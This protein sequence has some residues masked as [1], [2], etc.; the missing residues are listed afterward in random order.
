MHDGRTRWRGSVLA[1]LFAGLFCTAVCAQQAHQPN[2]LLISLDT[3][4]ADHL[5]CYGYARDTSPNLDR[6]AKEGVLF[7]SMTAASSW[8]V[9]SHMS[10]FTSLYPSVHGV[11]DTKKQLGEAVPTMAEILAKHGYTTAGFVTGPSLNHSMGFHR[12]FGFYDDFTVTLMHD[13]NLF[14]DLDADKSGIN[15]VPTNHVI[16]NLATAWL[17]KNAGEKFFLFLHYWDCH[18]DYI[19]PEPYDR[20]FYLEYEGPENGRNVTNRQAEL[21]RSASPETKKRLI[22]LYDGEIAHTDAHVGKMLAALDELKLSERTLVI[23][24]SDHGEGFWEH[25]RLHHGNNLYEELIHVPLLMRLPGVL[26]AGLRV[27]GNASHVDVLPTL[28]GLLGLPQQN[29]IHGSD[30]SQACRGK[31]DAPD[32][33]IYSEL[34]YGEYRMR[35]VR[36]G[37]YKVVQDGG[38]PGPAA[39]R[40]Q[41]GRKR[42]GEGRDGRE[43]RARRSASVDRCAQRRAGERDNPRTARQAGQTGREDAALAAQPGISG[44]ESE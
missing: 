11:E 33:P 5:G 1:I 23:I 25:G 3:L 10:M 6:F 8:T 16:T 44:V 40:A 34:N 14:H 28:L 35:A 2:V 43:G 41:R 24:V 42:G 9:P 22:A 31:G 4:R 39:G 18:N 19:P 30:L 26:P 20:K 37:P 21:E 38:A 29:A 12:G 32:R 13:E 17:H 15:Q 36:W 7:E 27:K